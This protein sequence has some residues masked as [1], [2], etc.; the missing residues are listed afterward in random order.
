[1]VSLAV[2]ERRAR[3]KEEPKPSRRL[4]SP[5]DY[6]EGDPYIRGSQNSAVCYFVRGGTRGKRARRGRATDDS[7]PSGEG[8]VRSVDSANKPGLD[9]V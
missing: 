7:V 9:L 3:L 2:P 8:G 4:R 5:M 1:M 6:V